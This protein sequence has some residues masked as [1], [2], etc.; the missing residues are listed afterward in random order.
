VFVVD[1]DD[2]GRL[3]TIRAV[4]KDT[5]RSLR[6]TYQGGRNCLDHIPVFGNWSYA[7]RLITKLLEMTPATAFCTVEDVLV[8]NFGITIPAIRTIAMS[9]GEENPLQAVPRIRL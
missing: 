4:I 9:L 5:R 3:L 1:V 8:H 7:Q 2:L 6:S